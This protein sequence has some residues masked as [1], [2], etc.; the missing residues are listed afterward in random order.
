MTLSCYSSSSKIGDIQ[1]QQQKSNKTKKNMWNDNEEVNE[2]GDP[3]KLYV[4]VQAPPRKINTAPKD[5]H[6]GG[7][8]FLE[9]GT[10]SCGFCNSSMYLLVQ[11]R[12]QS[13]QHQHQQQQQQQQKQ[14]TS[15]VDRYLSLFAC[16]REN[17]FEQLKFEKGF[18]SGGQ[19]LFLGMGRNVSSEAKASSSVPAAEAPT[20]SSWYD[21]GDDDS[22][23]W[24]VDGEDKDEKSLE[25][26]VAAMEINLD[27]DGTLK[28]STKSS[29]VNQ[30]QMSKSDKDTGSFSCYM[31]KVEN[32]PFNTRTALDEDDVGLSESDEKIRNMLARYMAEEEDEEILAAIRGTDMSGGGKGGEEDERLSEEDR[33]LRGFQDRLR[34][35]PRQVVRYAPGGKPLWSVPDKN[36]KTGKQLWNVPACQCCGQQRRFEFQVLPSVLATLEVDKFAGSEFKTGNDKVELAD[37]LSNGMNFGSIA[38]FT[39]SDPSCQ[40]NNE[41]FVVVQK[42]VDDVPQ[43]VHDAKNEVGRDVPSA[44]M[45]I[46][47]DLD[48]DD[49]FTPDG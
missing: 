5:S 31:L 14:T 47:E 26:A 27:Q 10:P 16:P 6:I 48:D 19:G 8:C 33:I 1:Y 28:A 42:S 35:V 37:L 15:P 43:K 44:T 25:K 22:N 20:K 34:R 11:L 9:G 3:V 12:L 7:H 32:E 41:P 18:S 24:G 13:D 38:A 36:R 39:C 45:A 40:G 21:D 30:K 49:E 23:E 2:N 29:P 46:V 4:P 17:C